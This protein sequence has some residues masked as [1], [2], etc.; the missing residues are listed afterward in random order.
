MLSSGEMEPLVSISKLVTE[1]ALNDEH[2]LKY[3]IAKYPEKARR[4]IRDLTAQ[5][6]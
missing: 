5:A 4:F 2:A 1:I 6:V 3:L